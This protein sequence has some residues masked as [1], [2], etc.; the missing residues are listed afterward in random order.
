MNSKISGKDSTTYPYEITINPIPWQRY[1]EIYLWF[2]QHKFD[3]LSD[4][5]DFGDGIEAWWQF[6]YINDA[7]LFKLT[8]C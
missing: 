3:H 5:I 1:C 2:A 7:T 8:W 6:K 4:Y